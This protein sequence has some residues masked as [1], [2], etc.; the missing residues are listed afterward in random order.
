VLAAA[1]DVTHEHGDEETAAPLHDHTSAP[2]LA[3]HE[4]APASPE[5]PHEH[6]VDPT[7][8]TGATDPTGPHT[9]PT[10]PTDPTVPT[11]PTDPT[12]L[13]PITSIDDPRLTQEQFDAAVELIVS[14]A[15]GMSA[16]ATE[17]DILAAGY[18]SIGDGT[19]PGEYEHFV[20]WSYL[21][22]EFEVDPAHIES[23][24]MKINADGTKRVVSAMYILTLGKTMTD[25]PDIAGELTTWHDHD[26]LCFDGTQL[27]ALATDGVCPLGVLVDTPPML[28]VWVEANPCGPFAAID[29]HGVICDTTH[30]H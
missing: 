20:N 22:D 25:V 14:T 10:D 17:E 27:V 4:H 21:A 12:D 3:D 23:I 9:H 16:F 11:D 29:E 7:D 28:H 8:P 24:V 6:P 26:N 18:T 5:E 30:T 13:G 2:D 15:A 1:H 19:E